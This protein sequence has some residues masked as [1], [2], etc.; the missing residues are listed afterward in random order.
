MGVQIFY[1]KGPSPLLCGGSR[2][3]SESESEKVVRIPKC[4][5]YC[6]N[7]IGNRVFYEEI[8]IFRHVVLCHCE[9]KDE[10]RG[11]KN[12]GGYA[13]RIA[14]CIL[15]AAASIKKREDQ[16]RRTKHDFPTRV[17]KSTEGDSGSSR[18]FCEL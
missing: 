13:I 14:D 5:I 12:K 2:A 15:D 8:S 16:F 1:A 11:L 10:E 18:A 6:V 4:L 7:F 9:R 3:E 17:A